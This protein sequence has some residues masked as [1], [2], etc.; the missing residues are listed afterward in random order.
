[1]EHIDDPAADAKPEDNRDNPYDDGPNQDRVRG[2]TGG[3]S[4]RGYWQYER[5][6]SRLSSYDKHVVK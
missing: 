3:S 1:M 6:R 4:G 2:G 5:R